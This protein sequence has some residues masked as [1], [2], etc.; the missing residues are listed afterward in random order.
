M[1]QDQTKSPALQSHTT[2]AVHYGTNEVGS[3]LV[4][5]DRIVE[6]KAQADRMRWAQMLLGTLLRLLA[7]V[8]YSVVGRRA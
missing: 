8:S 2:T 7:G 3:D 5:E 1:L 6:R 4:E